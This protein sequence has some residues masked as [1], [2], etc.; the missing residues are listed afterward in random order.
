[1]ENQ[2][3][4]N[5]IIEGTCRTMCPEKEMILREKE[6]LL[7]PFETRLTD[8]LGQG[9]Q[10]RSVA[11]YSKMVKEFSRPAAGRAD[12]E[13]NCLRPAPVLQQTVEYLFTSIVPKTHP[14]WNIVYEFV[15]DRLRA[16]RQDMVI[17]GITGTDA[18]CL[19]EQIVRFHLYAAYRLR[20]SRIS[21]FDPVINKHHLLECLKRLLYLYQ[22]TPGH[23]SNRVE[24]EAVYLLDNLGDVHAMSHYLELEKNL[25]RSPLL[26][27]SY[28]MSRA[29]VLGNYL[30]VL[31]LM[32]NLP[33]AMCLCAVS[34]HLFLIQINLLEI[35]NTAFSVKNCKFPLLNLTKLL[36]TSSDKETLD[37]CLQ[38]G[39][40]DMFDN[41]AL[42]CICFNKTSFSKP[43]EL[44]G[45]SQLCPLE[46]ILKTINVQD[47]LLGPSYSVVSHCTNN[48]NVT[49][50]A[51]LKVLTDNTQK[52]TIMDNPD[53]MARHATVN[54]AI[55]CIGRGRGISRKFSNS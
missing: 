31:R 52:M 23:H 48:S 9:L 18:I 20:E 13:P 6:H 38:C 32:W 43:K 2:D 41:T 4:I 49:D 47:L 30:H 37:L 42:D 28:E 3:E 15:F 5:S 51:G 12:T 17:Q 16:V 54:N 44:K 46:K 1:M 34:K 8:N 26:L 35:L 45:V 27:M 22:V 25:R 40:V 55:R 36:H 53:K 19:L 33:C 29:F 14:A 21:E 10:K 11:D 24:M 50:S 39:L 7:H